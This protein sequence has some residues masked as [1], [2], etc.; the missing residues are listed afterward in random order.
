MA[1]RHIR[2]LP[3][4]GI[5]FGLLVFSDRPWSAELES[6]VLD[7]LTI[8]E[9]RPIREGTA[10]TGRE[11]LAEQSRDAR[12]Q[13]LFAGGLLAIGAVN[14]LIAIAA[15]LLVRL[16]QQFAPLAV[17]RALGFPIRD[18]LWRWSRPVLAAL[19][20]GVAL[21]GPAAAL[22][23]GDASLTTLTVIVCGIGCAGWTLG[24]ASIAFRLRFVPNW[25]GFLR[26]AD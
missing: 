25:A 7:G 22:I 19:L 8:G 4:S 14:A 21:G 2:Q 17:R 26:E 16:E 24:L 9:R 20:G 23:V 3:A 6:L 1:Y 10:L 18:L 11:L 15:V 12:V 5:R 13:A